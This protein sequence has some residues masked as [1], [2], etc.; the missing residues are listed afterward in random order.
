MAKTI[1]PSRQSFTAFDLEFRAL[2]DPKPPLSNYSARR[3][4]QTTKVAARGK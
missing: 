3:I 4:K 2:C 1:L